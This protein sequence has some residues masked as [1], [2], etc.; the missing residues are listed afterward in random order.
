VQ[1][2]PSSLA[3]PSPITSA[4]LLPQGPSSTQGALPSCL[5][6]AC[7]LEKCLCPARAWQGG[8]LSRVTAQH[9]EE[10]GGP[11][12]ARAPQGSVPAPA[13]PPQIRSLRG[14]GCGR[15]F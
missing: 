11:G 7:P 4:S 8:T 3:Q 6:W 10:Q 2:G 12:Q 13:P 15:H 1:L 5:H 9:L 14:S